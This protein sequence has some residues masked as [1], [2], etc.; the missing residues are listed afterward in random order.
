M[1][2]SIGMTL[3]FKVK[4]KQG[5]GINSMHGIKEGRRLTTGRYDL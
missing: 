5:D 2:V 3:V 4:I 1:L